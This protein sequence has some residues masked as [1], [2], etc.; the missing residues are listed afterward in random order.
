[1]KEAS[2]QKVVVFLEAYKFVQQGCFFFHH[3]L[4]TP[5]TN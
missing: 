2:F 1:M 3:F 5:M 4:A